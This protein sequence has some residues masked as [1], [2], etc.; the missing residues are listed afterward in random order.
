MGEYMEKTGKL[1]LAFYMVRIGDRLEALELFTGSVSIIIFVGAIFIN[2][3]SRQFFTAVASADEISRFAYI[4][5][6][7]LGTGV[8][9]RHHSHYM[10]DVVRGLL[11][12]GVA[13][14]ADIL[15]WAITT[16][17]VLTLIMYGF[18]YAMVTISRFSQP[19]GIRLIFS[20]ICIPIGGIAML[21]FL[22]EQAALALAGTN[23]KAIQEK[24]QEG[25]TK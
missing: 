10:I 24:L 13:K 9:I 14:A 19:S 20:T 6:V 17:F 8:G 3:V 4:W 7:F 23:L 21:Y 1:K 12:G 2:V 11:K 18:P 16:V 25:G 15:T 5:A 22:L